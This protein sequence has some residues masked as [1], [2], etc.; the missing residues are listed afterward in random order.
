VLFKA[1]YSSFKQLLEGVRVLIT[2]LEAIVSV[3]LGLKLTGC[4][5]G[6]YLL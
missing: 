1:V 2:A 4:M 6:F 5:C 3:L